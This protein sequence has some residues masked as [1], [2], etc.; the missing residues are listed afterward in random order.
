MSI[1]VFRVESGLLHP[2]VAHVPSTAAVATAA[3]E[4]LDIAAPLAVIV[5]NGTATVALAKATQDQEAE[6]V[7]T[8]TQFATVKRV[9]VAGRMGLTRD[10]FASYVPPIL[11][12]TPA[13]GAE[14]PATFH[15][16]GTAS[17]FE[18]T[19]VVQLVRDGKVIQKQT[20][21]AT[22]GAPSRGTFDATF[23]APPGRL[24]IAAF[25]P[26]AEDGSPQHEVDVEVT[27]K[28]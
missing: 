16:S 28:P 5:S 11:V 18:A 21:T 8:L 12:E 24:T 3:L 10:D 6:I 25:A 15:V 14:V 23:S 22:Q 7:Y 2:Q 1:T 9:D 26:S 27:V 20:V 4:A 13:A 17:V 19:M